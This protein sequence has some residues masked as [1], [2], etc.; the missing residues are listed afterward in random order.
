MSITILYIASPAYSGST[1][2]SRL[3]HA[4]SQFVSVGELQILSQKKDRQALLEERRCSCETA[5]INRCSFWQRIEKE[6]TQKHQLSLAFIDL[7]AD[8][9]LIFQRNN[10]A[11][12]NSLQAVSTSA[13]IVDSSKNLQRLSR[14]RIAGFHVIPI[15][16]ERNLLGVIHSSI[17]Y[18]KNGYSSIYNYW[19]YYQKLRNIMGKSQL[20][21]Q[22]ETLV[23]QPEQELTKL[24]GYLNYSFESQQ[25][26]WASAEN[27]Y[28][29]G[30]PMR[31]QTTSKLRVDDSWKNN[32]SCWQKAV[33]GFCSLLLKL[34]AHWH[35]RLYRILKWFNKKQRDV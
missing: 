12:F 14:L 18:G 21:L 16:L 27:H 20:I 31:Y 11:F 13:I 34:P 6:L 33:I 10:H 32:L 17:K 9:P 23:T 8:D 5:P 30:N 2:L 26:D 19:L 1:L 29:S 25:Q 22:Y 7:N 3:L 35:Y 4:H 24:L 28:I 15:R